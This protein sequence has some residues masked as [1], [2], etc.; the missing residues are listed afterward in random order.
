MFESGEEVS[1]GQECS[2][3]N[4]KPDQITKAII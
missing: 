3:E 1:G 4:V 2:G